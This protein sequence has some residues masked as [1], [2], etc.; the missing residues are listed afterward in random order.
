MVR[1]ALIG[2]AYYL[3]ASLSKSHLPELSN[4]ASNDAVDTSIQNLLVE[5]DED[6][7]KTPP[8]HPASAS[9]GT[10][11]DTISALV[12][13]VKGLMGHLGALIPYYFSF[14]AWADKF[15]LA[16]GEAWGIITKWPIFKSF[17]EGTTKGEASSSSSSYF[18]F[19][20]AYLSVALPTW[21]YAL[22]FTP[23][24]TCVEALLLVTFLVRTKRKREKMW[25]ELDEENRRLVQNKH[26]AQEASQGET[27]REQKMFPWYSLV[28]DHDVTLPRD[29]SLLLLLC[30]L[31]LLL[32]QQ[33]NQSSA[34]E[35]LL[36]G[37][38][39]R[40]TLEDKEV[41]VAAHN[42]SL[43]FTL[44]LSALPF[45]AH[46]CVFI[47]VLSFVDALLLVA[48][49]TG[50]FDAQKLEKRCKILENDNRTL[51]GTQ[52]QEAVQRGRE[53]HEA[54]DVNNKEKKKEKGGLEKKVHELEEKLKVIERERDGKH[55]RCE[56]QHELLQNLTLFHRWYEAKKE[57][58]CKEL[59]KKLGE[60]GVEDAKRRVVLQQET[61]RENDQRLEQMHKTLVE[62][63]QRS[64]SENRQRVSHGMREVLT[65][66]LQ[67]YKDLEEICQRLSEENERKEEEIMGQKQR[68]GVKVGTKV[69]GEEWGSEEKKWP[70]IPYIFE[71]GSSG[72][73]IEFLLRRFELSAE[74]RHRFMRG[75]MA[76]LRQRERPAILRHFS[77]PSLYRSRSLDVCLARK[78]KDS[79]HEENSTQTTRKRFSVGSINCGMTLMNRCTPGSP[80]Q[81]HPAGQQN[82]TTG[83]PTKQAQYISPKSAVK[84][85]TIAYSP[86]KEVGHV[87]KDKDNPRFGAG[88]HGQTK[89][90]QTGQPKAAITTN[91]GGALLARGYTIGHTKFV[92]PVFAAEVVREWTTGGTSG[93]AGSTKTLPGAFGRESGGGQCQESAKPP[94]SPRDP[95]PP[96]DPKAAGAE[97]YMW[98]SKRH[99]CI[100]ATSMTNDGTINVILTPLVESASLEENGECNAAQE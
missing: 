10:T 14:E 89:R 78:E 98:N 16:M 15:S 77:A 64:M 8:P 57:K 74:D 82:S 80:P 25:K 72:V 29:D 17:D 1:A 67:H 11:N 34:N 97:K 87:K 61:Q 5:L 88:A 33:R 71:P 27:D 46:A 100:P 40:S 42:H 93:H 70:V 91:G 37:F 83:S 59:K 62:S 95:K 73:T 49:F 55:Q 22:L 68:R 50:F 24:I 19:T 65:Y 28:S 96:C 35:W 85:T 12:S 48:Y 51:R 39:N 13:A 60:L 36:P 9:A 56:E 92:P 81:P 99:G 47:P 31:L 84:K 6:Y 79:G 54:F 43:L 90:L 23:L 76:P 44:L 52:L 41:E 69:Q 66:V 45:C 32:R 38:S 75:G 58:E 7:E 3:Y 2:A 21:A 30:C 94:C 63:A 53:Q 86:K 4:E 18:F 20:A 26:L